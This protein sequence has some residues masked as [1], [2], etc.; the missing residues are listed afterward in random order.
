MIRLLDLEKS[1]KIPYET[2]VEVHYDL[3]SVNYKLQDY[4][5]S[6]DHYREGIVILQERGGD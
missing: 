1:E 4:Q 6:V 2:I 5:E 3:G